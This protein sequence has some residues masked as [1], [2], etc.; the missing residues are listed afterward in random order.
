[1]LAVLVAMCLGLL[2]VPVAVASA[3]GVH[4]DGSGTGPFKAPAGKA[5]PAPGPEV[6][7][8]RTRTSRTYRDRESGQM[9]ARI[10]GESMHF[11]DGGAWKAISNELVDTPAAGY[12]VQN[13]GNDYRVLFPADLSGAPIRVSR[14]DAWVSFKL[15]GARG[16]G[17]FAGDV[18]RYAD[19]LPGVSARYTVGND[20]VKEDLVFEDGRTS[21][22]AFSLAAAEGLTPKAVK[23]GVALLDAAGKVRLRFARPFLYDS[24]GFEVPASRLKSKLERDRTGWKLRLALDADWLAEETKTGP[25][26]LDPVVSTAPGQDCLIDSIVANGNFWFSSRVGGEGRQGDLDA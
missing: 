20:S 2:A 22:V 23:G 19:V 24:K 14:G 13:E 16:A 4:G 6:A 9:V 8:L 11:R 10:S 18:A 1:V 5:R 17:A 26:T 21:S 3:A 25:V 15:D 7:Q 12:A